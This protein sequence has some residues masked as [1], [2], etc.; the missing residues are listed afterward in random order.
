MS[1]DFPMEVVHEGEVRVLVPKLEAFV[2]SPQEYAPSKAPVFYNPVMELNRDF[3]VLAVQAYQRMVNRKITICEP[4]AGCGVRGIRFAKEVEGV[5]SV[6]VND[7]NEKAF[8][9]A[10]HNIALNGLN[11]IVNAKNEEANLLLAFYGA[12]RKR[13]DVVD[14]DPFGSPAPFIDSAIRAVRDGGLIALTATDMAPLCGVHPK[15]CIRKYGG[16]PLRTEYCNEVALRLLIGLT[17]VTAAKYEIGVTP[18]FSHSTDHYVRVYATLKHGAENGDKSLS[19]MGYILHCFKCFHRETINKSVL[20]G[21]EG[22][23]PECG[24]KMDYAGPLWLGKLWNREFYALMEREFGGKTLRR[25]RRVQKILAL[26]REEC[27]APPTY[28]VL[29]KLCSRMGLAV[30]SVKKVVA[31]LRERS[32]QSSPTHFNPKGIK[33]NAPMAEIRRLLQQ[34]AQG[35]AL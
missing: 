14:I 8:K 4:L 28:Y 12:P 2:E 31:L 5:K 27:D 25:K 29:D 6:L 35:F 16:K 24:S 21:H 32:F 20:L 7:I 34:L 9:L 17:A 23:C 11:K 1:F 18:L 33:T 19:Q 15:A 3:A 13:F 22:K 30:P 10:K 26:I